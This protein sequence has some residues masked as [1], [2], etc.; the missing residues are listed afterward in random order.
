MTLF[1]RHCRATGD[2]LVAT[3]TGV[4]SLA[5]RARLERHAGG[6]ARCAATIRD[7]ADG[8]SALR[9]A[10]APMRRVTPRISPAR[11]RLAL[12]P[13]EPSSPAWRWGLLARFGR[14]AES[15][16]AIGVVALA[17]GG[18]AAPAAS[19]RTTPASI[20]ESYFRARPPL[21]DEAYFRWI[22]FNAQ[23][24]PFDASA[25]PVRFPAGGRFDWDAFEVARS[26]GTPR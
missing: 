3:L 1:D 6:C 4:A 10:F 7:L 8:S 17:L 11:V 24:E 21:A 19:Q 18:L 23:L 16:L 15:S 5:E 2:Q 13:P 26:D 9:E 14:L 12:A 25:D 22:R 20:V